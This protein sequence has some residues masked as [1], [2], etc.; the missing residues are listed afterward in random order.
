MSAPQ[1]IPL[2]KAGSVMV[3]KI[4]HPPPSKD[5]VGFQGITDMTTVNQ[6]NMALEAETTEILARIKY[7]VDGAVST[8]NSR[9][10]L[11]LSLS[12]ARNST[13]IF[14][15]TPDGSWAQPVD[16][17]GLL[18]QPTPPAV[19][20]AGYPFQNWV[21]DVARH[22]TAYKSESFYLNAT[23]FNNQGMVTNAQF[24]PAITRLSLADTFSSNRKLFNA[25]VRASP[26]LKELITRDRKSVV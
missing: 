6:V 2:T 5:N 19:I 11:F 23:G 18:S 17:T 16:G 4:L 10:I 7:A 24:T 15:R 13:Y 21:Q 12:G 20:N 25:I 26:K 3:R 8:F 14:I 1:S 22:R 9:A